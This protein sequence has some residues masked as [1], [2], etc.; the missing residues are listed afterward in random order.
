MPR[1]LT[2]PKI[3][4]DLDVEE[5]AEGLLRGRPKR[6][7]TNSAAARGSRAVELVAGVLKNALAEERGRWLLGPQRESRTE[8][9]LRMRGKDGLRIYVIDR[10]FRDAG[11]MLWIVDFKTNRHEGAGVEQFLDEQRTRYEA[12]LNAYAAAF[13]Q[14]GQAGR[15]AK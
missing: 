3:W 12:Q 7:A 10:L 6:S 15:P 2:R 11:G 5:G 9:R 1:S 4:S 14:R 8:H 13:A